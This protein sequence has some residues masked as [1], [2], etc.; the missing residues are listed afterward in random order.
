MKRIIQAALVVGIG[1][2]ATACDKC[3]NWNINKPQFC[4]STL[5]QN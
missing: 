2:L 5:P 4:Q 1:F 3:G